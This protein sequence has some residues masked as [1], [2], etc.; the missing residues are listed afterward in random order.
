M[1]LWRV[2]HCRASSVSEKLPAGAEERGSGTPG[3]P[4]APQGT[5]DRASHRRN[6][7]GTRSSSGTRGLRAGL[8]VRRRPLLEALQQL[9][10]IRRSGLPENVPV[11]AQE[12]AGDL[13]A[14]VCT[15]AALPRR[16]GGNH[17]SLRAGRWKRAPSMSVTRTA[18]AAG[19]PDGRMPDRVVVPASRRIMRHLRFRQE[20][21]SRLTSGR[22]CGRRLRRCE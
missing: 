1:P 7:A 10:E 16:C 17:E 13:Q 22:A 4:A 2:E 5:D 8:L 18:S 14:R 19:A 12:I 6:A 15:H 20:R 9:Q 3:E 11:D 21:C